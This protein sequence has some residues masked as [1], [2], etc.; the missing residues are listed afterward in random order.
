[1]LLPLQQGDV[2]ATYADIE[3]LTHDVGFRPATPIEEGIPRFVKWY[4][5]FYRAIRPYT[6]QQDFPGHRFVVERL[7]EQI[8]KI[9]YPKHLLQI[10]VLDDSTDETHPFTERLVAEYRAM[11]HPIEY[12]H[13]KN[14]AFRRLAWLYSIGILPSQRSPGSTHPA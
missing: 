7:V 1:M 3:D 12:H 10:Q 6:L 5:E 4:R 13:R 8:V 2:P 11:G 14:Y 9:D